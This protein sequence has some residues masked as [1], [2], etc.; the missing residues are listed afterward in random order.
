MRVNIIPYDP[1][2]WNNREGREECKVHDTEG[3]IEKFLNGSSIQHYEKFPS[4]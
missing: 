3:T 4:V 2:A 1:V